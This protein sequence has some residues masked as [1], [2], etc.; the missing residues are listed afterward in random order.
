M[1][2]DLI[3]RC[4]LIT[5]MYQSSSSAAHSHEEHMDI[6]K[7]LE[8]KDEALALSLMDAHLSHVEADLTLTP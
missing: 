3:S 2:N 6:V 1:L 7:A 8:A 4:A 5:L